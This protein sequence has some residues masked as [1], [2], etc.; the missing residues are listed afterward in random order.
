MKLARQCTVFLVASEGLG[1]PRLLDPTAGRLPMTK[2]ARFRLWRW[3]LPT[4]LV[5]GACWTG[6]LTLFN[7]WTAGGP[8]TPHPE[9]YEQRGN[10]FFALTVLMALLALAALFINLRSKRSG[11]TKRVD[12]PAPPR[13]AP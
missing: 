9:I 6:N 2:L 3:A 10:L 13:T 1:D 11:G 5:V 8:P 7:W 4:L 12:P